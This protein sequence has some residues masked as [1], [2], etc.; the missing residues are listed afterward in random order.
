MPKTASRTSRTA[1]CRRSRSTEGASS[2]R[3]GDAAAPPRPGAALYCTCTTTTPCA[4]GN[5]ATD[6]S[7]VVLPAL[8]PVIVAVVSLVTDTPAMLGSVATHV[9]FL[10]RPHGTTVATTVVLPPVLRLT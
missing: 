1:W 7:T 10:A 9:V 2:R 6:A 3:G 4:P 5:A 8:P